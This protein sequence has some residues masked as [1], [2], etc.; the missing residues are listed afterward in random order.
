MPGSWVPLTIAVQDVGCRVRGWK[1][2][3]L[4]DIPRQGCEQGL[5][6]LPLSPQT[7][8]MSHV[9]PQAIQ[10]WVILYASQFFQFLLLRF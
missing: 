3:D 2:P 5:L 9:L 4:L 1:L 8:K 6:Y 10:S 7:F